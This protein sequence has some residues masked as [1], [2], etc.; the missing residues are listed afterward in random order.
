MSGLPII[1]TPQGRAALVNADNTGT[2]GL[3]IAQIG[4]SDSAAGVAGD[5]L[6][7][8]IKRLATF[9]GQVV[10]DDTV[11]VTIRDDTSAVYGM[12]AFALYLEDGTLL[13]W[14]AQAEVIL[15]KSAQAILLLSCDIQF[16]GLNATVLEFGDTN[17]TNPIATPSVY[18]VLKLATATE[19]MAGES[20]VA[21]ITPATLRLA[22]NAR[23]GDGAPSGFVKGL[24]NLATAAL[25]RAALGL[26]SASLRNEGAGNSL[27][28]DMLDGQHGAYYHD[29]ENLTNVPAFA[30]E[31]HEH[32]IASV[33]GLQSA[34]N[35]KAAVAHQHSAGDITSGT[36]D[37]ARIPVIPAI[38]KVD[39]MTGGGTGESAWIRLNADRANGA[40]GGSIRIGSDGSVY[41]T[42][43]DA[44][45]VRFDTAGQMTN[46]TVPWARLSGVPAF[47]SS[48][49]THTTLTRG[50]YLTGSN[51]NG[52]A[53]TTWAV[54]ATTTSNA[55]KIVARDASGDIHARLFRS[56]Y[57]SLNAN[58]GAIMTQVNAGG[59]TDNYIRP[60]TPAQVKAALAMSIAD[61]ANLQATLNAKATLNAAVTFQ[62]VTASR[63]NG[64][65]VIYFGNGSR[66]LYFDGSKYQLVSA[67][68]L[69]GGT[70]TAPAF[71]QSSSRRYKRRIET[72]SASDALTLLSG[73][74]WVTYRMRADGSHAAGAIAEEL[75]DGPLDFVVTRTN[76]GAPDG[77]NYQPLFVLACAALRGLTD[78]VSAL[79]SRA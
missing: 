28:A 41:F 52:G 43:N 17:W 20:G 11:H 21:A 66:Y 45:T 39:A 23:F 56:E 12:R 31:V 14:Y 70:V 13:A 19:A 62:D 22:L 68:L 76:N 61:V 48:A 3:R 57:A 33:T 15:E 34:L 27:D 5:V 38:S 24:L 8:E 63:G 65:G 6:Q 35:A 46:G 2:S 69:V 53:S 77:I 73:V 60:S 36:L 51:Y 30:P 29:F 9:S 67:P 64:T 7:G 71:A 32:T 4:V 74:R 10:A 49:H 75:A 37:L 25:L 26:G 18:G 42:F 40:V 44:T 79:E 1:L 16:A 72:I 55:S 50:S 58:I 54:D 78:R 47:A 59:A